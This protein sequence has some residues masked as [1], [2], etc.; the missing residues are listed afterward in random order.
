[1][2]KGTQAKQEIIQKLKTLFG[3]DYIGENANKH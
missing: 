3:N 2:A 1:M